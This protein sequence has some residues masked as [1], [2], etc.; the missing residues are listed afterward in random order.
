MLDL[1]WVQIGSSG[2]MTAGLRRRF[3]L[4]GDYI[5]SIDIRGLGAA[6]HGQA[7]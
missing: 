6:G 1:A 5:G 4:D 3:W 7:E 2:K